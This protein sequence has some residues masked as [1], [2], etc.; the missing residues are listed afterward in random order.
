MSLS[1]LNEVLFR[2]ELRDCLVSV[3]EGHD[4]NFYSSFTLQQNVLQP[5]IFLVVPLHYNKDYEHSI[6]NHFL[7]FIQFSRKILQVNYFTGSF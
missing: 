5:I 6:N 1:Y 7:L 3:L 4:V 2:D